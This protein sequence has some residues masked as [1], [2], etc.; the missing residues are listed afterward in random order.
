MKRLIAEKASIWLFALS[1]PL[2]C[3]PLVKGETLVGRVD[4]K[5]NVSGAYDMANGVTAR[6]GSRR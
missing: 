4:V 2:W 1:Q 5:L 3:I 6:K